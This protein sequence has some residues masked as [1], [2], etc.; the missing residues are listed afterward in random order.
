[1]TTIGTEAAPYDPLLTIDGIEYFPEPYSSAKLDHAQRYGMIPIASL[2]TL[3]V[4]STICLISFIVNRMI[5]WKGHYRTWV[6]YNQ[7]VVLVLNL[8]LAD[9]Q[10]SSAFL[11]NWHWYR[12]DQILAPSPPCFAQ[13]WLLH[14]GD[15][16]G[17]FFVLSI[18]LHTYYT[19]VHGKRIGNKTFAAIVVGIWT[20][21]YFLTAIGVWMHG[22]R[23]YFTAA[24]SWCWVS[25]AFEI[26][27]LWT[28]Y[29]WIF[30]IQFS[31]ILIYLA[32][33]CSLRKKTKRLLNGGQVPSNSPAATTIKAVNRIAVLMMLYPFVYVVL[34]LPLSAG[35][36]WT[37]SHGAEPTSNLYT[38]IAGSLLTSCGWVDSLLYTLTRKR[39]L[40]DT[41][42]GT[43]TTR[44]VHGDWDCKGIIQIRSA[45]VSRETTEL[46]VFNPDARRTSYV[47]PRELFEDTSSSGSTA[48]AETL[49]RLPAGLV[50]SLRQSERVKPVF[51][52]RSE[53]LSEQEF[54]LPPPPAYIDTR[55]NRRFWEDRCDSPTHGV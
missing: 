19:A 48:E 55:S 32:I 53:T 45:T 52:R 47:L 24:G 51:V 31:T 9:L 20:W 29:V 5:G 44:S 1:M 37:M 38:C 14:S 12:V 54:I 8:I 26:N 10:Q 42:P 40:Q 46:E 33:F 30:M 16:S 4:I 50:T 6:G 3:S 2:A 22:T 39:L 43:S 15:V 41:M 36:M 34:T 28:H 35:R 11:I 18:A 49:G 21:T 23:K 7:Y 13:G 17:G 25:S 27:R